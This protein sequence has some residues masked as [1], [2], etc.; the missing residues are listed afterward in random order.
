MLVNNNTQA[1]STLQQIKRPDMDP[2]N[3]AASAL[4]SGALQAAQQSVTVP[5]AQK[6]LDKATDRI[7]EAFAKTRVQLQTTTEAVTAST[8][9]TDVPKT[10]STTSTAR[11]EFTDYMSKSPAERIRE[12]LLKEQGLTEA[13]VQNMSQEKQD[14]ISKQ[15]AE[16]LKQQQEQQVAAKTTDPQARAV[17][18][19]LA[20]I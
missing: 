1:V 20:A 9:T 2:A 5:A 15:V 14:A 3:A 18:E 10:G 19:T 16:R 8:A 4:Y 13:D 11:S 17:K 12:Q 6:E 7:D